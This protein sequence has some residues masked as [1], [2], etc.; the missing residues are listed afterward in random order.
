M[1]LSLST[2]SICIP[3]KR[4]SCPEGTIIDVI[5]FA[6]GVCV[7][8]ALCCYCLNFS[9]DSLGICIATLS[10]IVMS[11]KCRYRLP[12]DEIHGCHGWQY[13]LWQMHLLLFALH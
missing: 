3:T 12:E 4:R 13:L 9:R 10:Y 5:E 7:F 8:A 11:P 2:P 6:V 1:L